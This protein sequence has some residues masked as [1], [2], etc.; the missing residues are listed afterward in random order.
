MSSKI[1]GVIIVLIIIYGVSVNWTTITG[2][3]YV[4][5]TFRKVKRM[6]DKADIG[7]DDILYDLGSGDGRI[8]I[9]AAKRYGARA[10]GVEIDPIRCFLSRFFKLIFG[11]NKRI[12]IYCRDFFKVDLSEATVVTTF[13]LQETNFALLDKLGREL[14]PGTKIIANHFEFPQWLLIDEYHDVYIYEI[15]GPCTPVKKPKDK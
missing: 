9:M 14:K 7:P 3:P 13:L 4:P 5:S 6:L 15:K 1:V 11:V 2:A 12:K 10:V 8:V